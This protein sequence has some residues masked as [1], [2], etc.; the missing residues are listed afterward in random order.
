ME[1][2]G[3][4]GD[5]SVSGNIAASCNALPSCVAFDTDGLL[6]SAVDPASQWTPLAQD[7]PCRGLYVQ[8]SESVGTERRFSFTYAY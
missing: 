4:L 7:Y 5:V 2:D 8:V 1:V 6:K 3:A